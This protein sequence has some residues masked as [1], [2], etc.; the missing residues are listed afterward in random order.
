MSD[1]Y[2]IKDFLNNEIILLKKSS[3]ASHVPVHS[4]EFI[5][6]LYVCGGEAVHSYKGKSIKLRK[7]NYV[8]IDYNVPHCL[9]KKSDDFLIINCLFV[10]EFIDNSLK[11]YHTFSDVLRNYLIGILPE[12][13]DSGHI[14]YDESGTIE[15]ELT[16]MLD[17]FKDK[18]PGYAQIIRSGLIRIIVTAMRSTDALKRQ[19]DFRIQKMIER[20]ESD[21]AKKGLLKEL[22]SELGYSQSALSLLFKNAFGI[23]Y[24]K[25]IQ[26][27][28]IRIS[29]R[30]LAQTDLPVDE[31][32]D[33]SGYTDV[34]SYRK[35]FKRIMGITPLKY[36]I[37]A[38]EH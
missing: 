10:P 32:A 22:S 21:F 18:N 36:R 4:H 8:F 1:L 23:T 29:S 16:L 25:Y 30:M 17:E 20:A 19:K 33:A 38:R 6:M 12:A 2:T 7:N 31:I 11:R 15:K 35:H 28:R 9:S 5:E 3:G 27:T 37:S 24:T 34:R 14:F 26:E 13:E